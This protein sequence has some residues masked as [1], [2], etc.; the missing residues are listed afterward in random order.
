MKNSDI[1]YMKMLP[2]L[3][4]TLRNSEDIVSLSWQE[5]KNRLE[6]VCYGDTLIKVDRMDKGVEQD[7]ILSFWGMY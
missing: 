6:E 1:V 4:E 2:R 3:N 7:N 5:F